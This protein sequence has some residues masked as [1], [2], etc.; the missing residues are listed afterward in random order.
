MLGHILNFFKNKKMRTYQITKLNPI[1]CPQTYATIL[2]RIQTAPCKGCTDKCIFK[3]LIWETTVSGEI[4][5]VAVFENPQWENEWKDTDFGFEYAAPVEITVKPLGNKCWQDST[6]DMSVSGIERENTIQAVKEHYPVETVFT[7]KMH[8][9]KVR[10]VQVLT[11]SV[12]FNVSLILDGKTVKTG[13]IQI[14]IEDAD[15]PALT[16]EIETMPEYVQDMLF[17]AGKE[18]LTITSPV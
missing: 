7:E 11:Y 1:T 6:A 17:P 9:I 3:G 18:Y 14:Q 15:I 16:A 8:S 13:I 2:E 4:W 5:N 12:Y 10:S